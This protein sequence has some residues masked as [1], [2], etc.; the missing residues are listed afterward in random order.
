MNPLQYVIW[1]A[2]E[3]GVPAT[4]LV[5]ILAFPMAATMIA[6]SRHLLGLRGFGIFIPAALAVAF[7][8]SG[9]GPG[10]MLL[11]VIL[12]V[13]TAD[14]LPV[15]FYDPLARVIGIAHAGHLDRA[16]IEI[17]AELTRR[18]ARGEGPGT[19]P[20]G[21]LNADITSASTPAIEPPPAPISIMSITGTLTGVPEPRLSR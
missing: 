10:L 19:V 5:L 9:M 14:C 12:G 4:N 7:V 16:R 13:T 15:F 2:V 17:H 20:T 8:A 3:R 21:M 18:L 11:A 6:A 1:R